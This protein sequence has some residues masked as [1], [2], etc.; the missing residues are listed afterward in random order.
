[1]TLPQVVQQLYDQNMPVFALLV[2]GFIIL[3][4]GLLLLLLLALSTA[5]SNGYQA[6]WSKWVA[7]VIF[8]LKNWSMVEVFFIGVLISLVKIAKMATVVIG[9][10]FWA[11]A[12]FSLCLTMALANLDRLQSW[13]RIE[14]LQPS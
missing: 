4:P 7:R 9:D 13:Q 10:S 14:A 12:A 11:Y 6:I 1:M 8:S 2:A 3:I 5:L